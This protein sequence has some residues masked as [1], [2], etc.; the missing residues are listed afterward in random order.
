MRDEGL[1]VDLSGPHSPMQ[2]SLCSLGKGELFLSFVAVVG[3]G[4][5]RKA[6]ANFARV[7]LS[8]NLLPMSLVHVNFVSVE[9]KV[10]ETVA[11]GWAEMYGLPGTVLKCF[12][13][14]TT[15]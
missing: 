10:F 1:T 11:H 8:V 5:R 6:T 15:G 13:V 9:A 2:G 3:Q 4:P 14:E 7:R 12:H